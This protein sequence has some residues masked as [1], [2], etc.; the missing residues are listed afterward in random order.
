MIGGRGD[1][2]V[3]G[4]DGSDTMAGGAGDDILKGGRGRDTITGGSGDD[5]LVG[6]SGFDKLTGGAGADTF[7]ILAGAKGEK[8][9]DF[10]VD[11]D[12][13]DVSA[14]GLSSVDDF[15]LIEKDTKIVLVDD[16]VRIHLMGVEADDLTADHFIF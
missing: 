2:L 15:T 3:L 12:V 13:L 8:I 16:N 11:E 7:V 1:D 9:T 5:T 10:D 14:L 6:G 4:G